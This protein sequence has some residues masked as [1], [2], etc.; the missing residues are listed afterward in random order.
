MQMRSW[1]PSRGAVTPV[2][3]IPASPTAGQAV[4]HTPTGL[5]LIWNGD[6]WV[7]M[8]P[9]VTIFANPGGLVAPCAVTLVGDT[10]V[11]TNPATHD[12]SDGFVSSV[13]DADLVAVTR[14]GEVPGFLGLT[15]P[16]PVYVA[17]GGAGGVT[18]NP[19]DSLN[20]I[21]MG[22]ALAAT[23]VMARMDTGT[24]YG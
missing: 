21:P 2:D 10:L 7:S 1:T 17:S 14:D 22:Y 3:T 6:A 24:G 5:T 8:V 19:D 16:G 13:I 4:L 18:H 11:I 9:G 12:R 23:R 15:A 20:V